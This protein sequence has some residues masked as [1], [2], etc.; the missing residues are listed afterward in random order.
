MVIFNTSEYRALLTPEFRITPDRR[1]R[2]DF[3]HEPSKIIIECEGGLYKG[4]HTNPLGYAGDCEKYNAATLLGFKKFSIVNI[5]ANGLNLMS[6]YYIRFI[7]DFCKEQS[8]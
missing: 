3:C 6:E 8:K 4:R 5:P 1:W 7:Y 2:A